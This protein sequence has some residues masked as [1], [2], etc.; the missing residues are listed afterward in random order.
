MTV[1]VETKDCTH[2]SDAELGEM[3]DLSAAC[4]VAFDFGILAKACEDWVLVTQARIDGKLHGF[5]FT[6][7]ERI[8]GT[9]SVMLGL[10]S[11]KRTKQR[12]AVIK[13]IMGSLYRRALMAF[14]DE[15]VL[16]GSHF[17]FPGGFETFKG[18]VDIVPRPGYTPTG[19][20]R[21]W[22]RRLIKRFET[23]GAYDER[24][25]RLTGTGG[26]TRLFDHEGVKAAPAELL[27]MFEGI[28]VDRGDCLVACG[29]VTADD[30]VKLGSNNVG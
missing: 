10:G 12:D 20:E 4:S 26:T 24:S 16:V 7:L 2:L 21:A 6:T 27:P 1:E 3:G 9:P 25:F 19:E 22:G 8:G 17:S 18:L 29:W 23:K 13:T 30:L 5:V 11:I 28:D 14:P 15:D